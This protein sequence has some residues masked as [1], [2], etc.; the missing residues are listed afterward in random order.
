MQPP[1]LK[2]GLLQLWGF[3]GAVCP[4]MNSHENSEDIIGRKVDRCISDVLIKTGNTSF[5]G[6]YPYRGWPL[7]WHNRLCSVRST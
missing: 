1:Q 3:S 5:P 7:R 4:N 2:T 6:K